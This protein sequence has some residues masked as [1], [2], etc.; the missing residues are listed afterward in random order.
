[1]KNKILPLILIIFIVAL[2]GCIQ[3]DVGKINGLSSTINE[4]LKNG[5]NYYNT[6]AEDINSFSLERALTNCNSAASEF[7]L[8]KSSAEEGLKYA[9][10]SKNTVFIEY[11]GYAVTEIEARL[12][13]TLQLQQAIPYLQ[14]KNNTTANNHITLANSYMDRSME[15]KAK[16]D[17]LVSQNPSKFK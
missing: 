4:H 5:D 3:S 8:A 1:M 14:Q 11:M 7:K 13:A 9:Q 16:K 6:A 12:N 17:N 10:N 15:Y 2:S